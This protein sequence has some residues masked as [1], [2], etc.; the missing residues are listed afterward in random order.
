MDSKS[1]TTESLA[2]HCGNCYFYRM[3]KKTDNTFL[4]LCKRRPPVVTATLVEMLPTGPVWGYDMS[5][6]PMPKDDW[7]GEWKGNQ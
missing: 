3:M 5:R 2:P 6:P 1:T 7:C 4:W